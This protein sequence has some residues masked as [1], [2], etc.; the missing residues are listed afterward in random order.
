MSINI[1]DSKFLYQDNW[2]RHLECEEY[3]V[4]NHPENTH[5]LSYQEA[6]RKIQILMN[7][8]ANFKLY[9]E[10]YKFLKDC[11][12]PTENTLLWMGVNKTT[13]KIYFLVHNTKLT[14]EK[15]EINATSSLFEYSP[16]ISS[17]LKEVSDNIKALSFYE[18]AIFSKAESAFDR[19]QFSSKDKSTI[20]KRWET[21]T[22]QTNLDIQEMD[23]NAN[24]KIKWASIQFKNIMDINDKKIKI[25][26]FKSSN[27]CMITTPHT[28]TILPEDLERAF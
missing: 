26:K 3:F 21:G 4:S 27:I 15:N 20:C 13:Q 7:T 6:I 19:L 5:F 8:N 2:E 28:T 18:Y 23:P 24:E 9:Y 14:S 22:L 1:E 10:R 16:N 25:R 12:S 17:E 11:C